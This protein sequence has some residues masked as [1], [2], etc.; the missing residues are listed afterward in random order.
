MF[1]WSRLRFGGALSALLAALA[2]LPAAAE[3]RG[4]ISF[5]FSAP[6]G[7][8]YFPPPPVFFPPPAFAF[9]APPVAVARPAAP[10]AGFCREYQSTMTI[11]GRPQPVF[12]TACLQPDGSWRI[13]SQEER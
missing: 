4:F 9:P 8:A 11:G 7:P 6:L 1:G 10:A 3:A 12:G 5:G 13:V 2:L